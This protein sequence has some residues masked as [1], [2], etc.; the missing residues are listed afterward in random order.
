MI[1]IISRSVAAKMTLA[2][3]L[4]VA[5]LVASYLVMDRRLQS[6]ERS[7][8]DITEISNHAIGILRINKD[9]VEMQR[10]ISVYGAS[11][12][13][14]VFEK[15]EQNYR[16][17]QQ[18]LDT[19]NDTSVAPSEQTYID[20]MNDLVERYGNNLAV[21]TKRY[22]IRSS[23]IDDDLPRIY[24]GA[25]DRL[26]GLKELSTNTDERLALT[27]TINSWHRLHYNARLFLT[28]KDYAKRQEVRQIIKTILAFDRNLSAQLVNKYPELVGS[29]VPLVKAYQS[30]FNKSVQ[31]NRNYFTLVNVVMA[32]DAIEFSALA[33]TL[34]EQSLERLQQIK[35]TAESSVSNTTQIL[36]FLGVSAALYIV[37]LALFFHFHIAKA[38]RRLTNSFRCFL[39]GD[40]SAP[41]TDTERKDEIGVLAGAANRFRELSKDLIVAKQAAERTSKVKSEFLANM[42]HEIRTP[43]NGI[44]GMAR[45]LSNTA[46]S[47]EQRRMLGMIR[48]SGTSLL[49]IINDILDLSKIEAGKIELEYQPVEL[50]SLLEELRHLFAEQS[51]AKGVQLFICAT[52]SDN[53]LIFDADE[54]RLK[55]VLMNLL[56][57]AVK[58]TEKGSVALNVTMSQQKGDDLTL[59][60]SISDTGIGIAP[61]HINSLFE[62]FAQADT[63]ITR[64]FGGTGLGLT[65]TS[66]LLA[67]M[68]S[69][70]KVESEL[71]QGSHFY[72]ELSTQVSA[73]KQQTDVSLQ[74]QNTHT[75]DFST[76]SVL[77]VEDNEVNQVVTE[78]LLNEFGISA[79]SIASDGEQAIAMCET[80]AYDIIFMDMQM[81]VL[82]GPQATRVIKSLP[83]YGSVP[84]IALTANV[85]S[86]DR[87]RCFDAGMDAF[88][89]KPIEY[90]Q[91]AVVLRKWCTDSEPLCDIKN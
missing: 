71:G 82:D 78:A 25:I 86:A 52:Q 68:G 23:L 70:L 22:T 4:V 28:K 24:Q 72:F 29:I 46:L 61:E 10:D 18:R 56:G 49:V 65:I 8:D 58:F 17:I 81:P 21:L 14:A 88:L 48:S 16:S 2:L 84:V 19:L 63:S 79:I 37:V 35:H 3:A 27:E 1:E 62:A 31:A 5:T 90:E 11:G 43:M 40:L 15:I 41:I 45:Q 59:L 83:N 80:G 76:L 47:T 74:E 33:D 26:E 7:V 55:Q 42:S 6:I 38:V 44:L 60:F 67:L 57:N 75:Q 39:Q 50:T 69:A 91:L 9:I 87:Q 36:N 34:R 32:G 20:A 53:E 12:S 51:H 64:R 54:T 73:Y 89:T 77:I 66:K 13:I 85:L 30:A